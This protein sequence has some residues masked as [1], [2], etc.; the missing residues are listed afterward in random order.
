VLGDGWPAH[1]KVASNL[2]YG[3]AAVAQQGQDLPAGWIG[4]C[5]ENSIALLGLKGNHMVTNK[6][7]QMVSYCQE[8]SRARFGTERTQKSPGCP[9]LPL[10]S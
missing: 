2:P 9:R 8:V 5:P 10:R 3:L 4:D 7:N 6:G 1:T